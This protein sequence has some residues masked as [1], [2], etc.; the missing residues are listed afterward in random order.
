MSLPNSSRARGA[1]IVVSSRLLITAA[2][3]AAACR[4][5]RS[6]AA[7]RTCRRPRPDVIHQRLEGCR[8]QVARAGH[9]SRSAHRRGWC[10]A[11]TY[12]ID[13][14]NSSL[15]RPTSSKITGMKAAGFKS[16]A[17]HDS[18][19]GSPPRMIGAMTARSIAA[20]RTC[21]SA[22]PDGIH[23]HR[24]Q[25]CRIQVARAGHDSRSCS[26]PR[27][28]GVTTCAIDRGN[29]NLPPRLDPTSS[30]ITGVKVAEFKAA[31][32]H[33]WLR[34]HVTSRAARRRPNSRRQRRRRDSPSLRP[35]RATASGT[36]PGTR[37]RSWSPPR[38]TP[39]A[40]RSL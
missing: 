29:S 6:I 3:G 22:R 15:R 24:L 38:G 25:G 5:A 36:P 9:D 13:R 40:E 19:S 27:M 28:G 35:S 7:T 8:I 17:R 39:S 21:R 23:D 37:R 30:T 20:T 18:R 4:P 26:P 32:A 33:R 12:A 2:D 10:D 34:A 16:R 14:N 1:P 31:R 11:M